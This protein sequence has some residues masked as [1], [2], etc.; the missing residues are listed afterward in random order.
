M[1]SRN[2]KP[3][4]SLLPDTG[5]PRP[6]L[7]GQQPESRKAG[8][9]DSQIARR[10]PVSVSDV[11]LHQAESF[12]DLPGGPGPRE[13]TAFLGVK[14]PLSLAAE[15][16]RLSAQRNVGQ[17]EMVRFLLAVGLRSVFARAAK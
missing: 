11:L 1:P 7:V 10:P 6:K 8:K 12:D 14:L 16:K 3:A 5:A 4:L 13:L 17:S 9:P 15:I 2:Q